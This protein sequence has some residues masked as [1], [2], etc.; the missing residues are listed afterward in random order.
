MPS[1]PS[2]DQHTFLSE[3]VVSAGM[4]GLPNLLFY[5]DNLD[6]LRR[7]VKDASVDLVYLDPPFKSDKN[8]NVLFTAK[9]GT[10]SAAQ[11][12]AFEDTWEWNAAA[13]TAL[14]ESVEQGGEVARA[15]RA[16]RTLLG[17]SDMLAYLSMMAPRLVEL[18]RVM[19]DTASIYLH[20]DPTASAHLRLLMDSVF[21]PRHFQNE[22]IWYYRGG[23]ISRTRFGRRH[24]V[25]LFYS[26]GDSWTFN[27][28]AVRTPYSPESMERLKYKAKAFRGEKVYDTYEPH[29]LGKHPDDVFEIQPVMP[30]AKARLGYPTQKPV[31]LL[32]RVIKASSNEGDVVLDPFCGCGTTIAAAEAFKRRWIGIDVTHL[33]IGLMKHRLFDSFGDKVKY[34]VVGEPTTADDAASLASEDPHQFQFWALGLVHARPA[35]QKKGADRGIDGQLYFHDEGPSGTTKQIIFSVKAGQN[36]HRNMVHELR[37][38]I[39][40]EGAQI[41]VLISLKQATKPML[42]DAASAGFYTSPWDGKPYP[43]LQLVTVAELLSGKQ[44]EYPALTGGDATFKQAPKVE[45]DV[46][47]HPSLFD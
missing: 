20:C 9:D 39:E 37:G 24:D 15:L 13:A 46:E 38:V 27:A 43:R 8:Y 7:H 16:F 45:A 22:I 33:A 6:V 35:E 21:G 23:G 28:D 10:R 14:R 47:P 32:E 29:Q 2:E 26:K 44:I 18:R 36:L 42:S 41:G 11:I 12:K 1:Q 34:K 40:R 5:G 31:A 4:A 3:P 17:D 19:K 30:S 25:L